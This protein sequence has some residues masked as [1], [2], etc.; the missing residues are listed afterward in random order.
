MIMSY[1]ETEEG[2]VVA[3]FADIAKGEKQVEEYLY[4]LEKDRN[5]VSKII[6]MLPEYFYEALT[7][8]DFV[9]L[10]HS[11]FMELDA[12]GNGTLSPEELFPLIVELS[13]A[14][15]YSVDLQ[16][17]ERFTAIF[18]IRG[19]GVIR[20]DEFVDFAR[21]LEIMSYLQSDEGKQEFAEGLKVLEDAK[22]IEDLITMLQN[23]RRQIKMV[24]PYLPDDL[25]DELLSEHFTLNCLER[26]QQLDADAS[27]TL[28][29]TEL[30]PIIMDMTSA[31]HLAL[32]LEQCKRFTDVFD[33]AKSGFISQ[34]EFVNFAR[35]LVVMAFLQ[36]E[37]GQTTLD[38]ALQ[39]ETQSV[40]PAELSV[41]GQS[42]GQGASPNSP[43]AVGHLSVDLDFYQTKAEKLAKENSGQRRQM[44]DMEEKMRKMEERMEL[45]DRKLRHASVDLNA[46]N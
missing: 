46:S 8:D 7:S 19:D 45:Q 33:D 26:F 42:I 2:K 15:P 16:Q 25:R 1:L 6:P 39:Q 5:S 32:D 36:T 10:C 40:R 38:I 30:Y 23:D 43:Q 11:K 17:C 21:F 9:N 18:D 14:H 24:I 35:F 29:P 27:G 22:Q 13:S 4:M 3:D 37:D 41:T 20:L 12:D 44:L 31:H 34:K 28:D